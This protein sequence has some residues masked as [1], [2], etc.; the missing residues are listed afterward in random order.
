MFDMRV[1][2]SSKIGSPAHKSDMRM[3]SRMIGIHLSAASTVM[4]WVAAGSGGS[5]VFTDISSRCAT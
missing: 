5:G 3:L 4:G 2:V 1:I